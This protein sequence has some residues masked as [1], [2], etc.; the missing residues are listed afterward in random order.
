[1]QPREELEELLQA[2]D[3]DQ[4]G[5]LNISEFGFKRH[6]PLFIHRIHNHKRPISLSLIAKSQVTNIPPQ[7]DDWLQRAGAAV[8]HCTG[9]FFRGG[10]RRL[11]YNRATLQ[12]SKEYPQRFTKKADDSYTKTVLAGP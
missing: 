3:V 12:I 1:M 10:L 8:P 7:S 4:D 11:K 2:G 9:L 6:T 5:F